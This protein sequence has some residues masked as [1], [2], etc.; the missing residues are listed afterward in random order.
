MLDRVG[1]KVAE[2][3]PVGWHEEV[4]GLELS[5]KPTRGEFTVP[6][7]PRRVHKSVLPLDQHHIPRMSSG[8]SIDVSV[9]SLRATWLGPYPPRIP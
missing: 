2:D 3:G 6:C 1:R 7:S 9:D 4:V 8:L 5:D